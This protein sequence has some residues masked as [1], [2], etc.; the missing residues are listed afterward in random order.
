MT[1]VDGSAVREVYL[2]SWDKW[3]RWIE[4][5][6]DFSSV[7]LNP[8]GR[9]SIAPLHRCLR[10]ALPDWELEVGSPAVDVGRS[11]RIAAIGRHERAM[12]KG[13]DAPQTNLAKSGVG[14]SG[15]SRSN[16]AISSF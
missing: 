13:Q 6:F 5:F 11:D 8:I 1:F 3:C 4:L 10:P 12:R 16:R 7:R 2:A 14:Q 9:H 15:I